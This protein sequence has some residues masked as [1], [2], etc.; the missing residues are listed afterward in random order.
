MGSALKHCT[1]YNLKAAQMFSSEKNRLLYTLNEQKR[2]ST[3][4]RLTKKTL[5]GLKSNPPPQKKRV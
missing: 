3:S 5:W 1:Y 4:Q 2:W